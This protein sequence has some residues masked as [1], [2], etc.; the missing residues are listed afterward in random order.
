MKTITIIPAI[1][2]SNKK[3]IRLQQGDFSS[4]KEYPADPIRL[5]KYYADCGASRIHIVDIDAALSQGNNREMIASMCAALCSYKCVIEVGGGVRKE[6]DVTALLDI[7]VHRINLGTVLIN[8]FFEVQY[9]THKYGKVFTASIDA[10]NDMLRIAGWMED[11]KISVEQFLHQIRKIAFCC[12]NYTDIKRDG[13]MEG[14]NIDKANSIAKVAHVPVVISGGIG[15]E[16]NIE[17]IVKESDQN[18]VGM[19][20]GRVLLDGKVHIEGLLKKHPGVSG[21][22]W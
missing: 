12:I 10:K 11:S 6:S 16:E 22:D 2:I 14:A 20:I 9:W 18:I 17:T 5:I 15:S 1:D 19:I 8:N 7:G 21:M 3:C 13:M 4:K